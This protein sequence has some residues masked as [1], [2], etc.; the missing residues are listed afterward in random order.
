MLRILSQIW[1]LMALCISGPGGKVGIALFVVVVALNLGSVYA[2]VR[3]VE[4]TGAFYGALEKVDADEAIRQVGIFGVIVGLN[5]ARH[6]LGQYVRKHLEMRWRRTLT[7]KALDI[8]LANKAYWHLATSTYPHWNDTTNGP[9]GHHIDNP[10]QRIAED[11]RLFLQGLLTEALDLIS[12]VV[13]L[14]SYVALLWSLANFPLSLAFIGLPIEI[15]HYMI[16]AAFIYVAVSSLLTHVLGSPLKGLIVEQQRREANF[17]FALARLRSNFEEV[18]LIGGEVA[19]RREFQSRFEAIAGNWRKLVSRDL[20]LGC[21]TYPFNHSVLRIPLFVALPGYLAGHVAF[22][23]L[24]QLSSAFTN[25]VT[26]LSWFIFSYRDLAD[27]VAAS[28]RLDGFL[29]AAR[30]AGSAGQAIERSPSPDGTLHAGRLAIRTPER[31]PLLDVPAFDAA[32]G[33]T[34]WLRGPSG[35]GKTTLLK[36]LA[37]LWPYG[38]GRIQ[39][40]EADLT[41]SPQRPYFPIGDIY[42]A[43]A[44]P[45]PV[46]AFARE[47]LETVLRQVGLEHRIGVEF[48]RSDTREGHGLSGGEQQRL[49]LAR[50]LLHKPEW[51]L[52]DEPTSALDTDAEAELLALVRASLPKATIIIVAHRQLRGLPYFRT[53]NLKRRPVAAPDLTLQPAE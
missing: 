27:L 32:P 15:P 52:L 49:V 43:V 40:P 46:E 50:V 17:R 11:C 36:A 10:D 18:A 23:G 25:V 4:W 1:R 7:Q 16:W 34:I 14:F 2:A 6:L 24:M 30:A 37:G 3:L 38:E 8:W 48:G 31:K 39:L 47:E 12:R 29:Q 41:F 33:E 35:L 13:G 51:V 44:Y 21:F 20:I 45:Q 42:A 28:S 9:R 22:G 26:T 5:S 19:E 53:I